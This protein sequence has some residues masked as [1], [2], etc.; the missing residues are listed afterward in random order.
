MKAKRRL[1]NLEFTKN[2]QVKSTSDHHKSTVIRND[3]LSLRNNQLAKKVINDVSIYSKLKL[4][5]FDK[6]ELTESTQQE[7]PINV[8]TKIQ[9]FKKCNF[10][11]YNNL[12]TDN[13]THS[14]LGKSFKF[15]L[16]EKE[17]QKTEKPQISTINRRNEIFRKN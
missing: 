14:K 12:K 3:L 16:E 6:S 5:K 13:K 9:S 4:N 10:N 1:A 17:F 2:S 8:K 7:A 15:N 11:V